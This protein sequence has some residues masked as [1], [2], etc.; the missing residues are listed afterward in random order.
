MTV[1]ATDGA[2]DDVE[3][4]SLPRKKMSGKKLVLFVVLPL[5]VLG[6]GGAGLY[7]SG[8]LDRFLNPPA[9]DPAEV[10]ATPGHFFDLPD[11]IVNLNTEDRRQ[12]FL[13]ISPTLEL[14]KAEDVALVERVMPR[15]VDNFQMYLRE[16]TLQDLEGS[17]GLARLREEL[18]LRVNA[19]VHPA[20]VREVLFRE[21]IVN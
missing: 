15:I 8:V 17:A 7:V 13:K 19:A 2:L 4:E 5:L 21:M 18:L 1:N 9:P 6:G 12:T 14:E 11:I 20:H 10:A 3:I 16:L